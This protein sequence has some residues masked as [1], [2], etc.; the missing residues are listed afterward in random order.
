MC[1][2]VC[3]WINSTF[4]Y[5]RIYE[6]AH[7]MFSI[8]LHSIRYTLRDRDIDTWYEMLNLISILHPFLAWSWV[9]DIHVLKWY[10]VSGGGGSYY[11]IFASSTNTLE[12]SLRV[13]YTICN[14]ISIKIPRAELLLLLLYVCSI[15][16]PQ[17]LLSIQDEDVIFAMKRNKRR[18]ISESTSFFPSSCSK[19]TI[20]FGSM[21]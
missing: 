3:L 10:G 19:S 13:V 18:P 8:I 17:V 20:Q 2:C 11:N 4:R 6:V 21:Q 7:F 16:L 14:I 9:E 5:F 1:V 12:A 15:K